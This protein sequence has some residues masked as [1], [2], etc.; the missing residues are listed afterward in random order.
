MAEKLRDEDFASLKYALEHD[1]IDMSQIT[2]DVEAMKREEAVKQHPFSIWQGSN[3]S[4]YTH[5]PDETSPEGRKK[6]KRSTREKLENELV[7][8]YKQNE[9]IPTFKECFDMYQEYS[10]EYGKVTKNTYDRKENDYNRFIKGTPLDTMRIDRIH[11]NDVIMFLDEV[12]LKFQGKIGRKAFNNLTGIINGVFSHAKVI[13]RY[14]CIYVKELISMYSPSARHF[15]P[16]KKKLQV[17]RDDEVEMIIDL[18]QKKYWNSIRHMGILFMLFTGL[19]IG[20]LATLKLTDFSE[21]K[22]LLIQRTLSKAKGEDGKS[23]RIVSDFTKTATSN[24]E[25]LLSDDAVLIYEH[26]LEL[27]KEA[28]EQSDWFMAENGDF[29]S[30]TKFDKTLR[31]LCEE[32]DIPVRSCHKLR[33]TYCSE[34]LEL[35]VSEKLVQ[36]QMRHADI[37]TTKNHYYYSTKVETEKRQQLNSCSRLCVASSS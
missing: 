20:E 30:D 3:G 36:E 22:K 25:I 14:S 13:K 15:K 19:R 23:H 8:L 10:L 27:R 29:V 2:T 9:A 16:V 28:G 1:M 17:F 33:K 7:K 24:G 21:D 37:S 11:E 31:A 4:W 6:I 12:L 32:L 5:I 34:L 26:V 35:G 18:I